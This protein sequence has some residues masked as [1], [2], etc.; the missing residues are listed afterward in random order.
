MRIDPQKAAGK[1]VSINFT[2]TDSND[3]LA[4][5]LQNSVLNYRKNLPE[6]ADA[7]LTL[8]RKDLQAVLTGRAK[9]DD[10]VKNGKAAVQGNPAKLAELEA[11]TTSPE[12]WFN[13]IT[14]VKR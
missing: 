8:E 6:K 2:F 1:T 5:S 3:T 10:L 4:L 13:I 7:A 12:F 14:P 11:V 9:L